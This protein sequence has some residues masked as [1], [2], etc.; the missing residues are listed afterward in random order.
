MMVDRQGRGA[1]AIQ[2]RWLVLYAAIALGACLLVDLA[3]RNRT[4]E[5][6]LTAESSALSVRNGMLFSNNGSFIDYEERLLL[7]ELPRTDF[8]R[9]GVYFFGTSNMKWA[10]TTW[11]LPDGLRERLGNYG[12]GGAAHRTMLR[13]VRYAGERGMY[14]AG[15]RSEVVLGVSFHLGVTETPASYFPALVRRHGL[16]AI[17]PDDRLV[18][19]PVSALARWAIVEKARSG[20]FVWNLGRVAKN[21]LSAALGRSHQPPHDPDYYRTTWRAYMGLDW[22]RTIDREVATLDRTVAEL[23]AHRVGVRIVLLPQGSWMDPLPYPAYYTARVRAVAERAGVPLLDWSKAL[24]DTDFIDSN[25]LTVAGQTRFRNAM[26][27]LEAD[28]LR[29]I[30][31][32]ACTGR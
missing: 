17:A 19:V 12:T 25:H 6:W 8:S 31:A 29:R 14:A 28:H 13:L 23:R 22:R 30:C 32:G 27:R 11:D 9:G 5:R 18:D 7:D 21:K 24:P 15:D 3:A 10:F 4:L 20:G 16:Y 26:L 1:P 2:T